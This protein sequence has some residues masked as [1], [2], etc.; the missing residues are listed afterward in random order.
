[1]AVQKC[2]PLGHNQQFTRARITK[3]Y[4]QTCG[5]QT[6]TTTTFNTICPLSNVFPQDMYA[7]ELQ[8]LF[9]NTHTMPAY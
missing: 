7:L 9:R 3:E 5:A 8:R 4:L 6:R 1:M 2:S